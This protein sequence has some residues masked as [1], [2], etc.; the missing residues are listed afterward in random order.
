MAFALKRRFA[1]K[2]VSVPGSV[3][4]VFPK[5]RL[6][7]GKTMLPRSGSP[8]AMG[9]VTSMTGRGDRHRAG[10]QA[11]V[12]RVLAVLLPPSSFT[13]KAPSSRLRPAMP[14]P[15]RVCMAR[16]VAIMFDELRAIADR[17]P[18]CTPTGAA[19]GRCGPADHRAGPGAPAVVTAWTVT[20]VHSF[21][22]VASV[23]RGVGADPGG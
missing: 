19:S 15:I 10:H 16:D 9:P 14:Q 17:L 1:R 21:E 18:S 4:A 11:L 7:A 12:A 6:A 20:A 8:A 22:N 5:K 23:C 3:S 2:G 13:S